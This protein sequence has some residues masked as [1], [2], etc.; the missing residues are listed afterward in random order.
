MSPFEAFFTKTLFI[1]VSIGVPLFF[2]YWLITQG[3][4]KL[5]NA[6]DQHRKFPPMFNSAVGYWMIGGGIVCI[7]FAILGFLTVLLK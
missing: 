6:S 1:L 2:S 7:L 5:K 4:K 3:N